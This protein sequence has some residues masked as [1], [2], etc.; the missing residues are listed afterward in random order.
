MANNRNT[1][2]FEQV[3]NKGT[4]TRKSQG[5]DV[6]FNKFL[7]N[8]LMNEMD[9]LQYPELNKEIEGFS[10]AQEVP[11]HLSDVISIIYRVFTENFITDDENSPN[12]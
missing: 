6:L 9:F 10:T 11:Q 2:N 1:Y 12:K 5:S 4:D 3:Y 7:N 8:V